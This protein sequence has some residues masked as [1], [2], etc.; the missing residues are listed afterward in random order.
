MHEG[1]YEFGVM[2]FGLMNVPTTLQATMNKALH[3]YFW[4]FVVVFFDDILIYNKS[5]EEHL[6]HVKQVLQTLKGNALFTNKAK[7]MFGRQEIEHLVHIISE[8]GVRVDHG[9]IRAMLEWLTLTNVSKVKGFLG[10]TWFY[11][12]FIK[13]YGL[14]TYV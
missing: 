11:K 10:T 8:G 6:Q 14:M 9:K 12:H 2:P 4:K 13:V 3:P 7:C 5:L 1:R